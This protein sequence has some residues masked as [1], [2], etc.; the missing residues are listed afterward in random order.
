MR[1]HCLNPLKF[2]GRIQAGKN[3]FTKKQAGL[4]PLKFGGRIQALRRVA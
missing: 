3:G 1:T 2:G 4:N